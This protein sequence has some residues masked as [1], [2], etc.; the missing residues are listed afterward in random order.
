MRPFI[1]CWRYASEEVHDF[2]HSINTYCLFPLFPLFAVVP[3]LKRENEGGK[4]GS[5]T[6]V[7][8]FVYR[9]FEHSLYLE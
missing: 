9:T 8:D 4:K 6:E 7:Q 1:Q 2:A 3:M 5:H